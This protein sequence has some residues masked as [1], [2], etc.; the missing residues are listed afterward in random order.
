MIT[1]SIATIMPKLNS[2]I[3]HKQVSLP[4]RLIIAPI[5]TLI[6]ANKLEKKDNP[7]KNACLH[8]DNSSFGKQCS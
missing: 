6:R 3:I 5:N 7:H 1:T 8:I 4:L 2:I